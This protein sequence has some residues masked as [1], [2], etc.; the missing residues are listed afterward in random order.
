MVGVTPPP[1]SQVTKPKTRH[2]WIYPESQSSNLK[3]RYP[4]RETR[5]VELTIFTRGMFRSKESVI[6]GYVVLAISGFLMDIMDGQICQA[7]E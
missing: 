4:V 5:K 1:T 2:C 7:I 6:L 3:T